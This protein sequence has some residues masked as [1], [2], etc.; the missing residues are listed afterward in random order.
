LEGKKTGP[1]RT[2]HGQ[3]EP[4]FGSVRFK[5]LKKNNF[6]SIT[7]FSPKPDRT[8]NAHP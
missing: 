5:N 4:V 1:N 3:F 7:Y 2:E 6:G 8:G